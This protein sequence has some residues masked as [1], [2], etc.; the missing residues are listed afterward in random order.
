VSGR[1]SARVSGL[2]DGDGVPITEPRSHFDVPS[3]V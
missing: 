3:R 1:V 2:L